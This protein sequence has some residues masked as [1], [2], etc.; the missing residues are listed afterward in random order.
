M[1]TSTIDLLRVATDAQ[2]AA[3]LTPE[4]LAS[5]GHSAEW[6][7]MVA[8]QRELVSSALE[9]HSAL[10]PGFAQVTPAQTPAQVLNGPYQ[11]LGQMVPRVHGL[12]VVTGAGQYTEH[13][14]LPGTL[15]T[16]TLRSPHPHARVKALDVSK[17]EQ[18]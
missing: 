5:I 12:G 10:S 8:E 6:Q 3:S 18:F 9:A 1:A 7:Q 13:M 15:Y 16:R 11:I 2:Y 4:E 17:A 14:S